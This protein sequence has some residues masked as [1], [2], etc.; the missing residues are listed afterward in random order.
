MTFA[1]S[2]AQR[3]YSWQDNYPA[4]SDWDDYIQMYPSKMGPFALP[5]PSVFDAKIGEDAIVEGGY[6]FYNYTEGDAKTHASTFR[7]YYPL[8]PRRVAIELYVMPHESYSYSDA[9]ADDFHSFNTEG[10]GGG[11]I[12]INTFIQLLQERKLRPDIALRY[13]LRTASGS[14]VEDARFTD[15]PGYHMDLSFGKNLI[16]DEVQTLR[17]YGHAG[18]YCWQEPD[19]RN[20]QDDAIMYG[21]GTSYDREHWGVKC[22]FSGYSGYRDDLGDKPMVVRMQLDVPLAEKW[23]VRCLY[24]YG[25][26]DFPY[27]GYHVNLVYVFKPRDVSKF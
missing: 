12:I 26:S 9:V 11:D 18:F 27:V 24:E 14:N 21:V 17:F 4:S 1:Y 15:S 13:S 5:I 22:D 16:D 10:S 19:R 23:K 2:V 25:L 3:D 6:T 7:L 8:M 20:R